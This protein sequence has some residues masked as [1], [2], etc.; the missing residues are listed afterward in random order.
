MAVCSLTPEEPLPLLSQRFPP[1]VAF[2]GCTGLSLAV[3]TLP[4]AFCEWGE[5]RGQ[6]HPSFS[7]PTA[8]ARGAGAS[9]F[10]GLLSV[11]HRKS[12]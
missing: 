4:G 8:E 11:A 10:S 9:H 3:N 2:P 5:E 7:C 12:K 6:W 1:F